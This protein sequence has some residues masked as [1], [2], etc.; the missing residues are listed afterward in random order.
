MKKGFTLIEIT[1]VVVIL[2]IIALITI[3]LVEQSIQNMRQ[4]SY[5]TQVGT[6]LEGARQWGAANRFEEGFPGVG[7]SLNIT[8]G[9]LKEGGFLVEEIENPLTREPFSN[10][11]IVT[12]T[13][14]S[15]NFVYSLDGH[16][17]GGDYTP[18]PYIL[19]EGDPIEYVALGAEYDEPGFKAYDVG[20]NEIVEPNG[21]YDINVSVRRDGAT[22]S[23]VDTSEFARYTIVYSV[24]D[25]SQTTRA[26]RTV[27]I[28]GDRPPLITF[29]PS[30]EDPLY[31]TSVVTSFDYLEG[32]SAQ[33]AYDHP[34]YTPRPV[35]ID[36][37]SNLI[38]GVPGEYKITYIAT[39]RFD[40]VATK[41]RTVIVDY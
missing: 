24:S 10:S 31:I 15:G 4:K 8:I 3:P 41:Q 1:A 37:M 13:N 33:E 32:I 7:E 35:P 25:G 28:Y 30:I 21:E 36:V 5:E 11:T 19:L 29:G 26:V 27:I 16:S 6:I 12:I 14:D 40:N 34:G 20:G 22:V 39:D 23:S 17:S 18:S 9:D 38:L 2:G